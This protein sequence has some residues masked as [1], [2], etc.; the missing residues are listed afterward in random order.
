M[1]KVWFITGSSRGFGRELVRAAL[2]AGDSVAATARRPDQLDELTRAYGERIAALPLDVTDADGVRTAIATAK[3]RFGRIDVVVNNAGYANVAPI[4]TGD[5][6]DFRT[7]F[8]TNFWGV[9]HVSRAAIP[10][11]R[12]QGGGLIIQFSSM[13]GR[14]GGSAGIASYQAA[15]F[16]I[17]GFSRVLQTETA[18]FGIKVLVVEPSGFATD[19]AGSSMEIGDIPA[20]YADTVGAMNTV[21]KGTAV[22]AGDPVRAA[23]ILVRLSRRDELPYHLPLGVNAVQGSIRQDETLLAE[24]RKWAAVGRS[25]DFAEPYPVDFPA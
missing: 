7:Q 13:G 3:E 12:A 21:R 4:E 6:A 22:S 16:A 19:W 2:E 8:E 17:D 5:E 10:V 1:S 24:D 20:H 25:A 18:P 9:Y 11:L 15:K 14:V 23:Q